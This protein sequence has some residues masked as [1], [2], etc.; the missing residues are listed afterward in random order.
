MKNYLIFG[1][2]LLALAG[3]SACSDTFN[4]DDLTDGEG[5][6][7]IQATIN[8]DVKVKS[9]AGATN[10]ELA[11]STLIWI[12]NSKGVV[13]KFN[14]IDEVPAGGV[15]LLS[16]TYL[17]EAW[18]GDSV[19]ASWTDRYFKGSEEF[20]I[21][22][23]STQAL[24]I[25]CKIANTLV[26]VNYEDKISEL[27]SDITMEVGHD[28][29]TGTRN[30]SLVF[31]E[32]VAPGSKAYFMTNSRSK[33]L[34]YTLRGTLKQTGKP[35]EYTG[36]LEN[37]ERATEYRLNVKHTDQEEE[38]IGGAWI[39][40]VVDQSE[41]EV[42]DSF[43]ITAAPTISGLNFDLSQPVSGLVG[44]LPRRSLWIAATTGLQSV[45]LQGAALATIDGLGGDDVELFGASDR[46]KQLVENA[47][48]NYVYEKHEDTGF[49]ELKFNFEKKFL[50]S[51]PEGDYSIA[52]KVTDDN[53]RTATAIL[54]VIP[55]N[56]KVLLSDVDP[57]DINI[58][59]RSAIVYGQVLQE[60]AVN[61][62]VMYRVRGMQ[63]W[64]K[65]PAD[66][67]SSVGMRRANVGDTYSVMLTDLQPA[68][69]YQVAVFCDGFESS[70][71]QEFTTEGEP[72]LPNAS[73]EDWATASDNAVVPASDAN[74]LY[75]DSGNHGSI[76]M[77]KNIT[78]AS[79][80]YVHSGSKSAKLES[81][82][83][84]VF[85]V[86]KFAAGNIF[87][88][89]Y[90]N[91]EGT[92]GVL[93]WGRQ[94]NARPKALRCWVKYTPAAVTYADSANPDGVVK[95]DMDRGVI[96]VALMNDS[97][98][99]YNGES[100]PVVVKTKESDRTL[101]AD[102]EA[103]VV[104]YGEKVFAEATPGD[105]LIEV[106]IPL[107]YKRT[108]IRP[109]NIVLVASASKMG[110]YFTG[111]PSVMYLDDVELIYE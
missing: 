106:V 111:G 52:I 41:V 45:E 12:S 62:G 36:K 14:G 71:Y 27:L 90:L 15:T 18:A 80:D 95:N 34:L 49:S 42:E 104:A 48:I 11:K 89:K 19:S 101:F 77:K 88:G 39:T 99:A 44:E 43:T 1:A 102:Y 54:R 16:G 57:N 86:G 59:S 23:G 82:F 100:W 107:D 35:F 32:T 5:R 91:T 60:D 38:M 2:S 92:D 67:V 26:S 37:V 70:S 3:L 61:Y 83:V 68:T 21:T 33:D 73:F 8:S 24:N 51:L 85:G 84:G 74:N 79:A 69:T 72:Q 96:Y 22:K 10:D 78:N 94:F 46:V 9:R 63:Q 6:L 28:P 50:N 87:I 17:A 93:G 105:G 55:T 76:T 47:G 110:D 40:I 58:T 31:D 108:D 29:A 25:E 66:N 75:W 20:T 4:P 7:M 65:V 97:K 81:Q 109:S 98:T 30:G 103:N 64:T 56:A 13:K 53:G